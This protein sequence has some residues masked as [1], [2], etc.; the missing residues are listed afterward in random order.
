MAKICYDFVEFN[1][2]CTNIEVYEARC[3]IGY[4][5]RTHNLILPKGLPIIGTHNN[6]KYLSPQKENILVIKSS[7]LIIKRENRIHTEKAVL[8]KQSL[9]K[10]KLKKILILVARRRTR[11]RF[12]KSANQIYLYRRKYYN[13]TR[14][15]YHKIWDD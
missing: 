2:T 5:C 4:E 6:E 15:C 9:V 10:K 11:I 7:S 13:L 12:I 3:Y 1:R 8:S 14:V